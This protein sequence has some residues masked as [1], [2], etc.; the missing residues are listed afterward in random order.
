MTD[1][2]VEQMPIDQLQPNPLQPRGKMDPSELKDLT[3]SIKQHGI[4]EPI[5]AAHTPAGF[6]IIAGERRWRAAKLAGLTTV[7]VLVK[8]TD[9]RGMLEMAII[10]NVQRVDLNPLDRA[11]AFKRLMD[12]FT[13]EAR[14]VAERIGKSTSY[15]SNT[16]RLLSLPDAIKD[17][18]LSHQITEGHARALASIEDTRHIIEAYKQVLREDANVRRTEEI[19]R[20]KK[21]E[22][23]IPQ[24][25]NRRTT[26]V[27]SPVVKKMEDKLMESFGER[28]K[29]HITRS[30]SQTRVV[31]IFKGNSEITDTMVNRIM[32]L[33]K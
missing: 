13:L 6:L 16:I 33:T 25:D 4:L 30:R 1:Q 27:F 22:I 11:K 20:R 8:E 31:F 10:E 3:D 28:S 12:E 14:A 32:K 29:V 17:G 19:A 15:I 9:P 23:G 18:L 26:P 5:V 2:H 24:R 21:S 7:P